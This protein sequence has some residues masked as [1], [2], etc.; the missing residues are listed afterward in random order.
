MPALNETDCAAI[1]SKAESYRDAMS[2]FLRALI[3]DAG[4]STHE[5]KH[6]MTIE[7]E[8]KKLDFDEVRVDPMGNILGFIGTGQTLI[9]FDAH[10]D[11]VGTGNAA[12]WSFDPYEGFE[13]DEEIGGRGASD[14]LGGIVAAIYGARIMK[15]LNLLSSKY[16]ILVTGTVQ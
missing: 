15:D 7:S 13:N 14:Q 2:K 8:M 12:N 11:T 6:V 5:Q 1:R 16:R 10:I 3:R 9:A 4:E